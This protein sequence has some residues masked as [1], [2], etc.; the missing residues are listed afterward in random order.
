MI[1]KSQDGNKITD[2]RTFMVCREVKGL[3]SSKKEYYVISAIINFEDRLTMGIYDT[4]E[5]AKK[6]LDS[7]MHALASTGDECY[8]M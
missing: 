6:A 3:T 7:L 1:V 8:K 4:E 5:D 2:S